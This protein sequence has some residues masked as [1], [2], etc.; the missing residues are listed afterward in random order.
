MSVLVGALAVPASAC[1][2]CMCKVCPAQPEGGGFTSG[3]TAGVAEQFTHF[4]TTQ[5]D[6]RKVPNEANQFL[7]SSISQVFVAYRFAERFGLQFNVPIIHRSFKR[8]E[9]FAT[10]RSTESGIGDVSL[11]GRFQLRK[12]RTETFAFAWDLVGGVKLPTG[13]TDR[14]QEELNEVEVEGA[15]ASGIHGHDLTLGSGSVD[16]IVG[17]QIYARWQR[18]F[19]T[20]SVHY[21]LRSTGDIDYRFANDLTW[22]GGPGYYLTRG[23][24]FTAGLQFNV[25]GE[26]KGRDIFRGE[27]AEDTGVTSIFLGPQFSLA[28]KQKF[29]V[30]VGFEM[31]AYLH[32]SAF[33]TV[34]DYRL[35]AAG[36]W[37]F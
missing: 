29:N 16:G 7:D 13:K 27:T 30:E 28:W 22:S 10:D 1:D 25:S 9:G 21:N 31:P 35:R 8:P 26:H 23:D 6:G 34:P 37:H 3:F 4:G 24:N 17:T 18:V 20:A 12:H 32:N 36:A 19:A 11:L 14:L 33:Q 15:P 5:I 2:L